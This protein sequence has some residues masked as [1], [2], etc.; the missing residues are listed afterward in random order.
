MRK[1]VI[2]LLMVVCLLAGLC[3]LPAAATEEAY[4]VIANSRYM[5]TYQNPDGGWGE[6]RMHLA[7]MEGETVM[8]TDRGT[9][10]LFP[11]NWVKG[12]NGADYWVSTHNI[13]MYELNRGLFVFDGK[14]LSDWMGQTGRMRLFY[15]RPDG[16]RT[17]LEIRTPNP[18]DP[19]TVG[20]VVASNRVRTDFA[21][22]TDLGAGTMWLRLYNPETP[23][24]LRFT[25]AGTP[26][27]FALAWVGRAEEDPNDILWKI[28]SEEVTLVDALSGRALIDGQ[29]VSALCQAGD[30]M[31]LCFETIEGNRTW[32]DLEIPSDLDS[33]TPD[34][35]LTIPVGADGFN[36]SIVGY[37]QSDTLLRT[38]F[39]SMADLG[40]GTMWLRSYKAGGDHLNTTDSGLPIQYA[41][42][43]YGR[44]GEGSKDILWR[45]GDASVTL[46]E[47]LSGTAEL[48]G[49]A[50]SEWIAAKGPLLLCFETIKG[51]RVWFDWDESRAPK[52]LS[53]TDESA[54]TLLL[55]FSGA[56][57]PLNAGVTV[58]G[59]SVKS[60]EPVDGVLGY[61]KTLRVTLESAVSDWTGVTVSVGA[62][63][64]ADRLGLK[65]AAAEMTL[66]NWDAIDRGED[67]AAL[68]GKTM[69]FMNADT[70]RLL[71]AGGQE[72]FLLE[73]AG[74]N[75]FALKVGEQYLDLT[76]ATPSL[77]SVKRLYLIR[78]GANERYQL[79]AAGV[80]LLGDGD[81]GDESAA[82]V[83][84]EALDSQALKTGWYLTEQGA[85]RP[86]RVMPIGDSITFGLNPDETGTLFGYRKTLSEKLLERFGRVV[87]VGPQ[88]TVET[89]LSDAYL[90]RHCGF[91]GYSLRSWGNATHP[92]FWGDGSDVYLPDILK[93]YNP[94]LTL[95]LLGVNDIGM[96]NGWGEILDD[97]RYTERDGLLS[98]YELMVRTINEATR[99]ERSN[100]LCATLTPSLDENCNTNL[101]RFNTLLKEKIAEWKEKGYYVEAVDANA[102]LGEPASDLSSDKLHL[103]AQGY[104][105]LAGAWEKAIE[106]LYG[107]DGLLKVARTA[108]EPE[109]DPAPQSVGFPWWTLAVGGGVLIAAGAVL[110]VVLRKKKKA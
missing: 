87:F 19:L 85:P 45:M 8:R 24:Y 86:L 33:L 46:L 74:G 96:L 100:L 65:N 51:D 6:G 41:L 16:S 12:E 49:R 66:Y 54:T 109:P 22:Y 31:I 62:A 9:E 28:S 44:T 30:R 80:S 76:A 52:L 103:S 48:D 11:L 106:E 71:S 35:S 25:T 60:V 55:H 21:E 20:R 17:F 15:E 4:G 84:Y 108:V 13:D 107:A 43:W 29:P 67:L 98:S 27:Q 77:G 61:S 26:I 89:E 2:S 83:S 92:D 63:L 40:E 34:T 94:D 38:D 105:K 59:G 90:A 73:A 82:A 47:V 64:A 18:I 39:P 81:E 56:V 68:G 78:K 70:G 42:S 95:L 75:L 10:L 37:L 53:V 50:L 36:H 32:F 99:S 69:S 7:C 5:A 79:A 57:K 104:E 14:P 93:K 101:E 1:K 58:A 102:A 91:S 110:F 23:G 72:E 97:A 88:V 3:A